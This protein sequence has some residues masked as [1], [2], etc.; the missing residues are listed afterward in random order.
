MFCFDFHRYV[1]TLCSMEVLCIKGRK[2]MKW[3]QRKTYD[4]NEAGIMGNFSANLL[5]AGGFIFVPNFGVEHISLFRIKS[6]GISAKWKGI[7]SIH[8]P[9][10]K[11]YDV[12]SFLYIYS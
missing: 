11:P 10:R 3:I 4:K 12:S 1:F 7:F 6:S 5:Q 2:Q 9:Y 8:L